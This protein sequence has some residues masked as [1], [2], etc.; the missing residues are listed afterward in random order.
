MTTSRRVSATL[1]FRAAR[2]PSCAAYLAATSTVP[3]PAVPTIVTTATT[4]C[5]TTLPTWKAVLCCWM[6]QSYPGTVAL[7]SIDEA[8]IVAPSNAP[9]PNAAT[10]SCQSRPLG[11]VRDTGELP[12]YAYGCRVEST[13]GSTVRNCPVTG[14]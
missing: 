3:A 13:A 14:S 6:K 10:S 5:V 11:S 7:S 2:T 4:T 8:P 9:N 1:A 12:V